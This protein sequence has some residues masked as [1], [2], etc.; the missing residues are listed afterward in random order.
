MAAPQGNGGGSIRTYS[1]LAGLTP[2][3][4]LPFID[5]ILRSYF[6]RRMLRALAAARGVSLSE[7]DVHLLA[8]Q[9]RQGCL[10]GCLLI[11]ILYLLK[12]VL[13]KLFLFL[14]W[15]RAIDVASEAYHFGSL[16]DY[17]LEKRR[18]APEGTHDAARVRAAVDAVLERRGTSP[19]DKAVREAFDRSRAA[20]VGAARGLMSAVRGLTRRTP[21]E[22]VEKA[23]QGVERDQAREVSHV[24]EAL[25]DAL[26]KVPVGYLEGLCR[27]LEEE[28]AHVTTD[29]VVT[30][31]S[32]RGAGPS[33]SGDPR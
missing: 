15:K 9:P 2:L 10:T 31:G 16:L 4:P 13:R 25:E 21:P 5:D 3:I 14:E 12:R 11:P 24:T 17:L 20:V 7:A 19:I 8:D 23:V 1:V 22:Q 33:V 28:L 29:A 26:E 27:L 6:R 30:D 18:L 32:G